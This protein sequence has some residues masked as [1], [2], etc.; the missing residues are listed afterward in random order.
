MHLEIASTRVLTLCWRRLVRRSE[1]TVEQRLSGNAKPF[2]FIGYR[3][4][5]DVLQNKMSLNEARAA[6]RQ[7]T[8]QYAKRQLT[9]FRREHGVHWLAGFG[10]DATVQ[11]SAAAYVSALLATRGS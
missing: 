7:S 1:P 4:L 10:D 11:R 5:R 9:W 6:I 2:D 3:E 8:R